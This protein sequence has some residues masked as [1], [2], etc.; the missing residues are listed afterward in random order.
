M[1][2]KPQQ[3][4]G[5]HTRNP[6]IQKVKET[7]RRGIEATS[8]E[9]VQNQAQSTQVEGTE[10]VRS[11]IYHHFG[12]RS[13]AGGWRCDSSLSTAGAGGLQMCPTGWTCWSPTPPGGERETQAG[14]KNRNKNQSTI[15]TPS[16]LPSR[17]FRDLLAQLSCH[18]SNQ[19]KSNTFS[20][21]VVRVT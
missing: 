14:Q 3:L 11:S 18:P 21:R 12:K 13:D 19:Q 6:Q 15:N 17:L 2:K 8:A 10:G 20:R 1:I 7:T 9:N 16:L 4:A 5:L